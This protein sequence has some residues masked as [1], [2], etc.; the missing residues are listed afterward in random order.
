VQRTYLCHG[1]IIRLRVPLADNWMDVLVLT[2]S[3]V[4]LVPKD[5]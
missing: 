4:L 5:K 3:I 2:L 1:D